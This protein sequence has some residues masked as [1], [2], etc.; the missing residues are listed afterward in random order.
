M[1][2]ECKIEEGEQCSLILQ[3]GLAAALALDTEQV[4]FIPNRPSH[5][6]GS[7]PEIPRLRFQTIICY[8]L[9]C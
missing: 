4:N 5:I 6:Q 9:P 8:K 7:L 1:H 2:D 3:H